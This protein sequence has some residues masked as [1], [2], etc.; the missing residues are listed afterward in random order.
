MSII[1]MLTD[2][3]HSDEYVGVMKGVILSID[4]DA[5]IIDLT[6]LI[7]PQDITQAAYLLK[8]SY[9]YFPKNTIHMV[10][11]DPGVGTERKIVVLKIDE[12]FFL[13]PDNGVLSLLWQYQ[14][15][16]AGVWVTNHQYF[17]DDISRTFHGRD[18]IAPVAG[19]L[20]KKIS[21]KYLGPP[22]NYSELK[23]IKILTPNISSENSIIGIVI[24]IDR[25]GNLLTNI[26]E[27]TIF[28]LCQQSLDKL[29]VVNLGKI[30][31]KGLSVSYQSVP[32]KKA[33]MIIG[34]RG[35]LEISVNCGNASQIFKIFKGDPIVISLEAP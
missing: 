21:I 24:S 11:V 12:H 2:F 19:W 29:P 9:P 18:I 32:E 6:H 23:T 7:D 27:R 17:L 25:F 22:V 30:F 20:S 28:Q 16:Q 10:V 13:A 33:L 5:D 35:Y 14:S 1:T 26:E 8:S 3:G 31:I 34:S 15:I 4:P